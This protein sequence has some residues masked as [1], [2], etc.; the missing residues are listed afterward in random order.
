MLLPRPVTPESLA[1]AI[2]SLILNPK[3]YQQMR[4]KARERT[5]RRASWDEIGRSMAAIIGNTLE[6]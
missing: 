6:R 5:L 1:A 2:E 4:R 3:H